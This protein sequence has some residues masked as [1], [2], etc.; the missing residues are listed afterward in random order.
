MQPYTQKTCLQIMLTN[1]HN[2]CARIRI[3]KQA[4]TYEY[5]HTEAQAHSYKLAFSETH[6]L[7]MNGHILTYT[8]SNSQTYSGWY[9]VTLSLNVL[10]IIT[11]Y[12]IISIRDELFAPSD[13][14]CPQSYFACPYHPVDTI[15]QVY[16]AFTPLQSPYDS[17]HIYP[18][19][20]PTS[21]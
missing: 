21:L 9:H 1:R 7:H 4:Y 20:L 2:M 12:L 3:F 13:G 18:F 5:R 15:A 14:K 17:S 6:H 10:P 16:R 11:G 8:Q 19:P